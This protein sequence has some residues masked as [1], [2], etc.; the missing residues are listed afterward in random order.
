MHLVGLSLYANIT[1][2]LQNIYM[3]INFC[4]EKCLKLL[5]FPLL[6]ANSALPSPCK[7]LLLSHV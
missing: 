2:T 5:F 1:G 7:C 6:F 4:E 3:I